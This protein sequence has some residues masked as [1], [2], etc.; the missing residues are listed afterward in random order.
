MTKLKNIFS[1]NVIIAFLLFALYTL[2]PSLTSN[3]MGLNF[4]VTLNLALEIVLTFIFVKLFRPVFSKSS[5]MTKEHLVK[6][7]VKIGGV[8]VL[9]FIVNTMCNV[10]VT[11]IFHTELPNN[12]QLDRLKETNLVYF[13]ISAIITSPILESIFFYGTIKEIFKKKPF[14]YFIV[15]GLLYGLFYVAF[16][17][18]EAVQLFYV[19]S[20]FICSLCLSISYYKTDNIYFPIGVR[21]L[22]GVVTV[23]AFLNA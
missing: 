13:I 12:L 16:S 11:E 3:L 7:L 22:S 9:F 1:K 5:K 15:S 10:V 17:Y 8:F 2:L 4:D 18:T 23:L 21:M 20:Y 19:I 6:T 14:F